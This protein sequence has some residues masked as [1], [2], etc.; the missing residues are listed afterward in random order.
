MDAIDRKLLNLLT[1]NSRTPSVTLAREL[2]VS[3]TTV[4]NRIERLRKNHVIKSF[5][6]ALDDSCLNNMI[7][8]LMTVHVRAGEAEEVER[9]FRKIVQIIHCLSISGPYDYLLEITAENIGEF[10]QAIA[11]IRG[12][13]GVRET[14]SAIVLKDYS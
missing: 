5:T 6:V 13:P 10:D 12:I 11:N 4:Q 3:R 2:G 9:G 8:G 14:Q 1:R 7:R